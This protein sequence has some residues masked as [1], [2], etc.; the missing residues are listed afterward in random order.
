MKP[1]PPSVGGMRLRA[2]LA[3]LVTTAAAL[4]PTTTATA[5]AEARAGDVAYNTRQLLLRFP[6]PPGAMSCK[7]RVIELNAGNY[8]WQNANTHGGG[9][10]REIRLDADEYTWSDCVTYWDRGDGFPVYR[11]Q[12]YLTRHSSGVDAELG[13]SAIHNGGRP[14]LVSSVYGSTLQLLDCV[15]C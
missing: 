1:G 2:L 7:V 15:V 5:T 13:A 3:V 6:A 9:Q 10:R 4:L 8:L 14:G 11:H 12:S